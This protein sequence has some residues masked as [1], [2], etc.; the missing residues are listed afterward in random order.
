MNSEWDDIKNELKEATAPLSDHAWNDMN[1]LL[2]KK[3]RAK[4]RKAILWFL[5]LLLLVPFTWIALETG[6]T[7]GDKINSTD[8]IETP[9]QNTQNEEQ[10]ATHTKESIELEENTSSKTKNKSA[11]KESN[12]QPSLVVNDTTATSKSRAESSQDAISESKPELKKESTELAHNEVAFSNPKIE[13]PLNQ[14]AQ[15]NTQKPNEPAQNETQEGPNGNANIPLDSSMAEPEMAASEP[16]VLPKQNDPKSKTNQRGWVLKA[17]AGPTYNMPNVQY[18]EQPNYTHRH[19][20]TAT[21]NALEAGWGFDAGLELSYQVNRFLKLGSGIG[22]REIVTTNNYTHQENEIPVID[23]ATGQILGYIPTPNPAP[24][25]ENAFAS[26]SFRYIGL[27]SKF[28]LRTPFKQQMV[29]NRRVCKQFQLSAA[30][31]QFLGEQQI[32]GTTS[33]RSK[34]L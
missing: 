18:K 9:I 13:L 14:M 25:S 16:D 3:A 7:N 6:T 30:T 23:S 5:P 19:L 20:N 21:T 4:R 27:P 26:N 10:T 32:F 17:Y 11:I 8:R 22:F 29:C 15:D 2:D 24:V 31:K 1:A 12:K 28:V 33:I 34:H